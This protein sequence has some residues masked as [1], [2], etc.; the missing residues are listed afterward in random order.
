MEEVHHGSSTHLKIAFSFSPL[1]AESRDRSQVFTCPNRPKKKPMQGNRRCNADLASDAR[2]WR[3]R[4]TPVGQEAATPLCS[5]STPGTEVES[6][7]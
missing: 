2:Q 7:E 4:F 6:E 1:E 5:G 3:A